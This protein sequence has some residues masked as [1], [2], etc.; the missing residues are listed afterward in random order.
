MPRREK[1]YERP[2][3]ERFGGLK[4]VR[5]WRPG[6]LHTVALCSA[7]RRCRRVDRHCRSCKGLLLCSPRLGIEPMARHRL[8]SAQST[9]R[10]G[11]GRAV[12]SAAWWARRR[13]AEPPALLG[14]T[15]AASRSV[16][17]TAAWAPGCWSLRHEPPRQFRGGRGRNRRGRTVDAALGWTCA[18]RLAGGRPIPLSH[19]RI[20][21]SQGRTSSAPPPGAPP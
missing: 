11:Q 15:V 10:G 1:S 8:L 13:V 3:G 19:P 20:P 12:G 6:C 16:A 14:P 21:G 2:R 4:S 7:Q 5:R 9:A 17:L 18:L